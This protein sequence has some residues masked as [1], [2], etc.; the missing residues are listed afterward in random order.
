M[1][2]KTV[3]Q[4]MLTAD[5]GMYLTDGQTCGKTVVLPVE[6]DYSVWREITAGEYAA[7]TEKEEVQP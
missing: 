7:M 6:A 4:R 3:K 2:M 1:E 5:E